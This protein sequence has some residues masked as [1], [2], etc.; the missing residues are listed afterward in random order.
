[1][2]DTYH[3]V[4][5][6]FTIFEWNIFDLEMLLIIIAKQAKNF[7]VLFFKIVFLLCTYITASTAWDVTFFCHFHS[8]EIRKIVFNKRTEKQS[9]Q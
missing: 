4:L 6:E 3:V 9:W 8:I 1:M 7:D 2:F 5:T